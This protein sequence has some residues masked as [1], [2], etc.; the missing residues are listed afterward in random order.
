MKQFNKIKKRSK[1]IF[2]EQKKPL[3]YIN[4]EKDFSDLAKD[5]YSKLKQLVGANCFGNRDLNKKVHFVKKNA[6][7]NTLFFPQP[8]EL[9]EIQHFFKVY[10]S[11]G[12][13]GTNSL[14]LQNDF[15]P[16]RILTYYNDNKKE[17]LASLVTIL[18]KFEEAIGKTFTKKELSDYFKQDIAIFINEFNIFYYQNNTLRKQSSSLIDYL[19]KHKEYGWAVLLLNRIGRLDH[20]FNKKIDQS[21]YIQLLFSDLN[22][23]NIEDLKKFY[24]S[25]K[26]ADLDNNHIKKVLFYRYFRNVKNFESKITINQVKQYINQ[27]T[28]YDNHSRALKAI[29]KEIEEITIFKLADSH[30]NNKN[31]KFLESLNCAEFKDMNQL[32]KLAINDFEHDNWEY[33]LDH[34]IEET[35]EK[36][37]KRVLNL[38]ENLIFI[39]F[40]INDQEKTYGEQSAKKKDRSKR[41]KIKTAEKQIDHG[42]EAQELI[43]KYEYNKL[44]KSSKPELAKKIERTWE[45]NAG[46][47]YDI[48]TYMKKPAGNFVKQKIEIKSVENVNKFEFF[49]SSKQRKVLKRGESIIYIVNLKKNE[50]II[51]EKKHLETL[52]EKNRVKPYSYYVT[53]S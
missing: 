50:C 12:L 14:G 23:D 53:N 6:I 29:Q 2:L 45:L 36:T 33:F 20:T 9:I 34:N 18:K 5:P 19:K 32:L 21:K 3:S 16:S 25:S 24:N 1:K 35:K 52:E 27:I 38:N 39:E 49:L 40:E 48:I 28:T 37:E 4:N 10:E 41:D 30:I 8:D 46:A 47:G 15:G 17:G 13:M 7:K 44:S 11:L 42:D 51:L 43:Y 31:L 26:E 22:I